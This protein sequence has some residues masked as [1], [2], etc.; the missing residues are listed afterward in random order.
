M[1]DI[2]LSPYTAEQQAMDRR[3]KM[4]EALQQQAIAPI[5]MPTVP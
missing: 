4:A 5:E 1:V 3:R 2:N